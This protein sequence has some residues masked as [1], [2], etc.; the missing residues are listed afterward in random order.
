GGA[1]E[2]GGAGEGDVARAPVGEQSPVVG[3]VAAGTDDG[4][5][6]APGAQR[7]VHGHLPP[8]AAGLA[9]VALLLVR[10][11]GDVALALDDR[12][13][14]AEVVGAV[15]ERVLLG[16][17]GTVEP[18]GGGGRREP[19]VAGAGGARAADGGGRGRR[20]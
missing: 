15:G 5:D 17:D 11:D 1:D 7:V 18:A 13:L 3:Q 14:G 19:G 12:R 2:G 9:P 20:R 16:A 4:D 8:V 6:A 10:A